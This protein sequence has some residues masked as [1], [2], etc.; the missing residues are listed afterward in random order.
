MPDESTDSDIDLE[1]GW[2]DLWSRDRVQQVSTAS[3]LA[4]F[5]ERSRVW[6]F[7]NEIDWVTRLEVFAWSVV[8][9]AG[10]AR[11]R[12]RL[13]TRPSTSNWIPARTGSRQVFN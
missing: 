11:F 10:N 6:M 13:N 4:R 9:R 2:F 1:A 8:R 7:D 5:G 3:G 12:T